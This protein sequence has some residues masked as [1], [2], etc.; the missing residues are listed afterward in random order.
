MAV[1]ICKVFDAVN[2]ASATFYNCSVASNGAVV[3]FIT[4]FN[5]LIFNTGFLAGNGWTNENYPVS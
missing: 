5:P 2:N 3:E 1:V 4:A